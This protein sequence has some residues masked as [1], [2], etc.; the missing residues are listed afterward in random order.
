[1]P[2]ALLSKIFRIP[3]QS[4]GQKKPKMSIGIMLLLVS[5]P[6]LRQGGGGGGRGEVNIRQEM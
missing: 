3:F 2:R 5:E 1:M 6:T 4:I